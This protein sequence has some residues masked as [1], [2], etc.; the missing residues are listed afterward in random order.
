MPPAPPTRFVRAPESIAA[1]LTKPCTKQFRR[2]LAEFKKWPDWP[3][4]QRNGWPVPEVLQ[5]FQRAAGEM[6]VRRSLGEIYIGDA[7]GGKLSS[8]TVKLAQSAT[9]GNGNEP[10]PAVGGQPLPNVNTQ[11]ALAVALAQHFGNRITIVIDDEAVSSWR[12]GERLPTTDTPLPP[13]KVGNYWSAAKW[14]EWITQ[15]ILPHHAP[16]VQAQGE[17]IPMARLQSE[18]V[19]AELEQ[20]EH[21]RM[22][23]AVESGRYIEVGRAANLRRGALVL[24][25]NLHRRLRETENTEALAAWLTTKLAPHDLQA[26]REHHLALERATHDRFESELAKLAE[27]DAEKDLTTDGHG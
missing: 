20:I 24:M 12:K 23:R 5:F 18:R 9:V 6:A 4:Q 16:G 3:K 22:L 27:E 11:H 7:M 21:D 17:L 26:F 19:K 1:L 10:A 25:R 15:Y 2:E 13:A 8:A 14:A